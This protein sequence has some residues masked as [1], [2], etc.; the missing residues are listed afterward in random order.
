ME[1]ILSPLAL[2]V[3]DAMPNRAYDKMWDA[4]DRIL[5]DPTE[6]QH[7]PRHKYVSSEKV[8]ATHI[9]GTDYTVYWYVEDGALQ[10]PYILEDA[11]YY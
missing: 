7:D 2:A 3:E 8:W 11:G 6:A 10:V 4:F 1:I 9:P 5:A